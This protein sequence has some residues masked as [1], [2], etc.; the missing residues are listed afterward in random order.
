M[1]LITQPKD[2][3]NKNIWIITLLMFL[4]LQIIADDTKT[5]IE[6]KKENA[7]GVNV[8]KLF[9]VCDFRIFVLS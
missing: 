3:N 2:M 8:I 9:F 4:I 1:Y 6:N 7:I 5:Y